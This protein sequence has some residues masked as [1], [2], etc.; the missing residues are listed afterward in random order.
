MLS[1]PEPSSETTPLSARTSVNFL[2]PADFHRA[3]KIHAAK[4]STT[5]TAIFIQGAQIVI[6]GAGE[7]SP[8][9][10]QKAEI[11]AAASEIGLGRALARLRAP[12]R[13]SAA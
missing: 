9:N 5:L 2:V 3:V 6:A 11:L 12:E 4:T 8:E 10:A 13:A 1:V 7:P